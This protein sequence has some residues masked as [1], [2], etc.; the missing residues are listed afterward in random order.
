MAEMQRSRQVKIMVICQYY[1][2]A[3]FVPLGPPALPQHTRTLQVGSTPQHGP[4]AGST[5][6]S[7]AFSRH[8]NGPRKSVLWASSRVD[9]N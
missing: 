7:N 2:A 8:S 5:A 3:D 4:I 1:N 9:E 6:N